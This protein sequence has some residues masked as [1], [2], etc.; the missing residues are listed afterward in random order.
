MVP[1][2]AGFIPYVA[3]GG[4]LSLRG[5]GDAMSDGVLQSMWRQGFSR[6]ENVEVL[7]VLAENT[8]NLD[9]FREKGAEVVEVLAENTKDFDA[10]QEKGVEGLEV[11]AKYRGG[12]VWSR[13][14]RWRLGQETGH[15]ESEERPYFDWAQWSLTR[16]TC[17]DLV[18]ACPLPPGRYCRSEFRHRNA[19]RRGRCRVAA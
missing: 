19:I 11:L 12:F 16:S 1:F 4:H 7:E 17:L 10:W 2:L 6:C 15:N 9:V 13:A 14:C 5:R 18:D 8:G 3:V